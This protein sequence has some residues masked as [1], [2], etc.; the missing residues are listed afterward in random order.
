VAAGLILPSAAK[1]QPARKA[2]VAAVAKG[3]LA[4]DAAKEVIASVK[5]DAQDIYAEAKAAAGGA[6]SGASN[7]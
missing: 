3:M 1:S 7:A 2:A 5:E 4:R 6:P